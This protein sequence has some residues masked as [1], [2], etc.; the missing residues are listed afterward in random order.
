MHEHVNGSKKKFISIWK[1]LPD[2]LAFQ[3]NECQ[4]N[5]SVLCSVIN[6]WKTLVGKT[7]PKCDH[8]IDSPSV[9]SLPVIVNEVTSGHKIS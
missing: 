4:I 7:E 2:Y 1:S 5:G 6:L 3:T 9:H 8:I